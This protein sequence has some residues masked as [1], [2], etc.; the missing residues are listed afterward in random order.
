[1]LNIGFLPTCFKILVRKQGKKCEKIMY[2]SLQSFWASFLFHD[3][4]YRLGFQ[5]ILGFAMVWGSL[6]G[7]KWA[8]L[9]NFA[10]KRPFLVPN[11]FNQGLKW[12][13]IKVKD[14]VWHGNLG[15][16]DKFIWL[17]VQINHWTTPSILTLQVWSL[18]SP[19]A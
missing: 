9:R 11:A 16:C 18:F 2:P 15:I 5:K 12:M 3:I 6:G 14:I 8:W 13:K 7:Q 4:G 19:R 1:M 10:E 17:P